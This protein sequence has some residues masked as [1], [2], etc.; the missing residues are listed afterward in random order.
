MTDGGPGASRRTAP[1][2]IGYRHPPGLPDLF[3]DRS[4]GSVQV[5]RTLAGAGLRVHTLAS[6]YGKPADED[7]DDVD[8]LALAGERGWAV[9]MKD[10]KIRYRAAETQALMTAGVHGFCLTNG[11]LRAATM[12]AH[13][14][15][16]LA[17]MT[18]VCRRPGPSL[19]AVS[20]GGIREIVL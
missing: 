12:A 17:A 18:E 15:S 14:L 4:L 6:V 11:N 3:L 16:A 8:W 7:V 20:A 5:P 10:E 13:Y 9:L 1:D 19:Y 2:L